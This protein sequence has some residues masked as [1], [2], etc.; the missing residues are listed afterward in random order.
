MV[1]LVP[2]VCP[3]CGAE[4]ELPENLDRAFCTYCGRKIIISKEEKHYHSSAGNVKSLYE[5]GNRAYQAR[6]YEGAVKW[7]EKAMAMD[8]NNKNVIA[9]IKNAYHGLALIYFQRAQEKEEMAEQEE[10]YARS[11][12]MSSLGDSEH[13]RMHDHLDDISD[14]IEDMHTSRAN[15]YEQQAE[16][17]KNKGKIYLRKAGVCPE[18]QGKRYCP[19]CTGSGMCADCKGTGTQYLI[20]TCSVCNGFKL[21]VYC[22]GWRSCPYCRGSGKYQN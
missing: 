7:L 1:K 2:A 5:L 14:Q 9:I 21:C 15:M 16:H 6:D 22:R 17:L 11:T 18:C 13:S 4:L 8:A 12:S 3:Q 20:M 10:R 19:H